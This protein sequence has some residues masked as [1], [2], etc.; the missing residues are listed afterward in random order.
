MM[1]V[2]RVPEELVTTASGL[3]VGTDTDSVGILV[4]DGVV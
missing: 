1:I 2:Y 4:G 3:D